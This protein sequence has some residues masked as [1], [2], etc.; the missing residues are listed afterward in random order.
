MVYLAVLL[1]RIIAYTASIHFFPQ[2]IKLE[3]PPNTCCQV[4]DLPIIPHMQYLPVNILISL[5]T[6]AVR[7]SLVLMSRF[8]ID[9][10]CE[11]FY[12]EKHW[13]N[14]RNT[15]VHKITFSM[16]VT[17]RLFPST[18]KYSMSSSRVWYSS[19]HLC[20]LLATCNDL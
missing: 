5:L 1:I 15:N 2:A 17:R 12:T 10:C 4:S 18:T 6:L 13:S 9:P 19:C 11:D 8:S 3:I 20:D 7:L 14:L 16:V